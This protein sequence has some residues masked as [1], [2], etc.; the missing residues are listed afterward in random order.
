MTKVKPEVGQS[1]YE[2]GFADGRV[3][4]EQRE[5][6]NPKYMQGWYGGISYFRDDRQWD[7]AL[8]LQAVTTRRQP[9]DL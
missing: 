3:G 5:P 1:A 2:R 6:A 9:H 7:P 8:R 4:N